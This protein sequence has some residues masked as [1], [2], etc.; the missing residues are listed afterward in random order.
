MGLSVE[1]ERSFSKRI[2]SRETLPLPHS[3]GLFFVT[4]LRTLLGSEFRVWR[5]AVGSPSQAELDVFLIA[6]LVGLGRLPDARSAT[7]EFLQLFPDFRIARLQSM[8][9]LPTDLARISAD[10]RTAG[11]P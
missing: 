11:V 7:S 6:S 2:G 1:L 3:A 10:L 5:A 9:F 8:E 4:G